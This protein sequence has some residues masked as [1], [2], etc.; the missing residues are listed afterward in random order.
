MVRFVGLNGIL[1]SVLTTFRVRKATDWYSYYT[2]WYNLLNQTKIMPTDPVT[3]PLPNLV[4]SFN[5]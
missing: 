3:L 4:T 2:Q 5:K 1:W